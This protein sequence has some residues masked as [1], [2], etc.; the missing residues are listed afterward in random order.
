M[1]LFLK[2]EPWPEAL[3]VV[4]DWVPSS[5]YHAMM[6]SRG[7]VRPEWP[8]VPLPQEPSC[9]RSLSRQR[10]FCQGRGPSGS[11]V[12]VMEGGP[13]VEGLLTAGAVGTVMLKTPHN[14]AKATQGGGS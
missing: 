7:R 9:C 3:L 4:P 6:D 1:T 13:G 8:R 10:L 11:E 12:R 14:L 2:G 5:L